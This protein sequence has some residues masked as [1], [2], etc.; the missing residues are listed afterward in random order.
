MKKYCYILKISSFKNLGFFINKKLEKNLIQILNRAKNPIVILANPI[1]YLL[2]EKVIKSYSNK[3][4]FIG[5]MHS[6]AD[7]VF[8]SKGLYCVYPYII[9]NK[10]PKL[11][12]ILFL[13]TAYSKQ[14]SEAYQIPTYKM[15]AIANP[16]P[17]YINVSNSETSFNK[18]IISFGVPIRCNIG[19]EAIS[20]TKSKI[21]PEIIASPIAL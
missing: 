10:Y 9:K 6:S 7:F 3:A 2:M 14:I 8:D 15:G 17:R 1:V 12:K 11:D 18:S 4:I 19:F 20:P 13:S 21:V 16:L 5:Q